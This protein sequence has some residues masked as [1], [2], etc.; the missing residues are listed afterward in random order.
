MIMITFFE[1]P[2]LAICLS[3]ALR[4]LI[5]ILISINFCCYFS[6]NLNFVLTLPKQFTSKWHFLFFFT[7]S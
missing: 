1:V 2:F 6:S 4:T 3:L 5:P 7:P